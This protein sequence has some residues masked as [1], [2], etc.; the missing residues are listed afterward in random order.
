MPALVPQERVPRRV[1]GRTQ[2]VVHTWRRV[3]LEPKEWSAPVGDKRLAWLGKQ[4][5]DG[6][7]GVLGT[8]V[9]ADIAVDKGEEIDDLAS[10]HVDDAE[11][12]ALR[13]PNRA[14]L[15]RRNRRSFRH[16]CPP[17]KVPTNIAA[18]RY[19]LRWLT[20]GWHALEAFLPTAYAM[21]YRRFSGTS[22]TGDEVS[23]RPSKVTFPATGSTAML[24]A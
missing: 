10:F 24:G 1:A 22:V 14:R 12:L 19:T 16:R 18:R 20:S 3:F 9:F 23:N 11:S 21:K 15:P 4:P 5:L 17:N 6:H 2:H 13:N 7:P 8:H